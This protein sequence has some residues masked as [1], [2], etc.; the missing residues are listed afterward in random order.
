MKYVA[1]VL[2]MRNIIDCSDAT[3]NNVGNCSF[4]IYVLRFNSA[5]QFCH[6]RRASSIELGLIVRKL[7]LIHIFNSATAGKA[8][9]ELADT[10]PNTGGVVAFLSLIHI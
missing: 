8:L 2:H 9:V 7:S 1:S 5:D 6:Q 10:V 4:G 3:A